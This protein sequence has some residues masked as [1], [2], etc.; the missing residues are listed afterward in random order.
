[1]RLELRWCAVLV[2][3]LFTL[4]SCSSA[5]DGIEGPEVEEGGAAEAIDT[6]DAVADSPGDV[7]GED[8]EADRQVVTTASAVV[9]V[10]NTREASQSVLDQVVGVG[11]H[12]EAREEN[13]DDDGRPTHARLTVR[14]PAEDLNDVIES[15]ESVGDVTEL[16]ESAR[17]VTGTVRDLDARIEALQTSAD[18]LIEIMGEADTA[19]ELLQV[20]TTLSERQADLESLQAERNALGDQVSMSTLHVTLSTEPVSEVEADGFMGGLQTG[21]NGL[22]GFINAVLVI[23]GAAL[24]W[25]AVFAVPAGIAI[26]LIRKRMHR[27]RPKVA[28]VS[29]GSTGPQPEPRPVPEEAD[30]VNEATPADGQTDRH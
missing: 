11:G 17:D 3:A 25:F 8:S 5:E 27:R 19:E 23:T 1:M 12:V 22:V 9:E 7:P 24:P 10:D 30:P 20:E 21:W 29:E 16:S 2:M 6:D 13:T 15:L 4:A 14:V 26:V 18:R 28:P